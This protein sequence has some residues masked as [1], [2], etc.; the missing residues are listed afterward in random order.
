ML[1]IIYIYYITTVYVNYNIHLYICILYRL[2]IKNV[3]LIFFY[4]KAHAK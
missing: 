3:R 2:D 4:N 1:T